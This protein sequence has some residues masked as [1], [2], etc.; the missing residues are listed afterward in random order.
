MA[1]L[2]IGW[3]VLGSA[4][5]GFVTL[6]ATNRALLAAAAHNPLVLLGLVALPLVGTF[7]GFVARRERRAAGLALACSGSGLILVTVLAGL[8]LS[9]PGSSAP[10]ASAAGPAYTFTTPF[11]H[12][13]VVFP[14]EPQV[15]DIEGG[16]KRAEYVDARGDSF[17]RAEL[18]AIGQS[19]RGLITRDWVIQQAARYAQV[20]G[21]L[22]STI[23]YEDSPLG[24]KC[25]VQASRHMK[26]GSDSVTVTYSSVTYYGTRSALMLYAGADS[27]VYPTPMI[28]EF[29]RS[30]SREQQPRARSAP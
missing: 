24:P 14:R 22:G 19:S 23:S 11:S 15:G 25:S 20:N 13:A 8:V 3:V 5:L 16:G 30:V 2:V 1:A 10:G 6:L 28:R 7:L 9:G 4:G 12:Y 21:L 17:V 29:Y 26:K 18:V 27:S